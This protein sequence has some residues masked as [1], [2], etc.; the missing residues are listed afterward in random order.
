VVKTLLIVGIPPGLATL[1]VNA[2]IFH[3]WQTM[4]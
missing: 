4:P 3:Y 1:G 2:K